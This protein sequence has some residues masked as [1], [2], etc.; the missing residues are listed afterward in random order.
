M[1]ATCS[2]ASHILQVAYYPALS[3]V[4]A[5]TL[6]SAGYRVTSVLG[7][8]EAMRLDGAVMATVGLFVVGFCA[9]HSVRAAMVHWFNA[10]YPQIPVVVLQFHAWDKFPEADAV[11]MCEDCTEWGQRL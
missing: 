5:L 9:P 4:R 8:G 3:E 7:N 6:T 10:H 11:T 1:G 2:A